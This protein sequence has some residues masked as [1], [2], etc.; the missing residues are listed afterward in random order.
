MAKYSAE[1][2]LSDALSLDASA[3]VDYVGIGYADPVSPSSDGNHEVLRALADVAQRAY[4][5]DGL[6]LVYGGEFSYAAAT[7][8]TFGSPT[9]LAGGAYIEPAMAFGKLSIRPSLRYDY[10]S[11]FSSNGLLSPIGAAVGASFRFSDSDTLKLNLSKSYR[12]PTFEDLYWPELAGAEGNPS[13]LPE[14]AYEVNFGYE[15]KGDTFEYAATAYARYAEGVILWQPGADGIWRP[16][17]YGA[18]LYPGAELEAS[19]RIPG[20]YSISANYSYLYTFLL[21]GGLSFGDDKRLPMTPVHSLK[22]T[23][24]YEG[25]RV[26]WS[27]TAVY[28]G[29]RFLTTANAAYLPAYATV[30]ILMRWEVSKG[31]SA[32][33][34]GDNLF[35][36]QYQIVDGYPMPGT[37]IRLGTELKF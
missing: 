3:K 36:E 2:F 7:S 13:L 32:Y 15:R 22:G 35:D 31:V 5:S 4:V 14:T 1:R 29:L 11:D 21:S 17:N 12:V 24:S 16:S 23:L 18:A 10:Y 30:D 34:A 19:T 37:R 26:S 28:S 8:D 6:T 27:A 33:I 9:R 20:G 25:A